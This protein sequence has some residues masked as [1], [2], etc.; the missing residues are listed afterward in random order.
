MALSNK[1]EQSSNKEDGFYSVNVDLEGRLMREDYSE[2]K[3]K[4][5]RMSPALASFICASQPKIGERI[6]SYVDQV[7]RL[8]GIVSHINQD[9]FEVVINATPRKQGK[10]AAQLTWLANK[11]EMQ[12]A[13]DRRHERE[14]VG[15]QNSEIRLEDGR[16]YPCKIID[17][18]VSGA[19]FEVS[20]RPEIGTIV[21]LGSMKGHIV[22]HFD[23]G[24]SMEFSSVRQSVAVSD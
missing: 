6:V 14:Y 11:H 15:D 21:W 8:E 2:Q 16:T 12:D 5:G 7:G 3:C 20:I 9:C 13:D 23:T 17:L 4:I 18:S 24:I 1:E 10:L 22:R 19:A